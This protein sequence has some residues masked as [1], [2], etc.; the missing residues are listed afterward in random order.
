MHLSNSIQW[1][2]GRKPIIIL[3]WL[4]SLVGGAGAQDSRPAPLPPGYTSIFGEILSLESASDPKCHATASRLE[5][6]VYGTP[7]SDTARFRKNELASALAL[8]IWK[9]GAANNPDVE[10]LQS[11][12]IQDALKMFPAIEAGPDGSWLVRTP[13]GD[14]LSITERD[15]RQYS[16]IAYSLRAILAAQ[17]QVTIR[18]I[19]F[20]PL[21][22]S[23]VEAMKEAVDVFQL[24][25]L[26]SADQ[27]ARKVNA[28]EITALNM[29]RSWAVV[30]L[31]LNDPINKE[32]GEFPSSDFFTLQ[33]II[34]QKVA[35][36]AT[37]NEVSNQIFLRNL[38]VYFAKRRWP[39]DP[40]SGATL[41]N[42]IAQIIVNFAVELYHGAD[43]SARDRHDHLIREQDVS[44]FA[45]KF[46]AHRINEYED[47]IF[48]PN[49]ERDQQ[50]FIESY[51][52]DSFRDS[53]L[54]W[55][56][57]QFALEDASF[58]GQ[59]GA[60]PFAA[61][62]LAE[63]IAQFGVLVL[64]I[65]GQHA[66][67]NGDERLTTAHFDSGLRDLQQ[68]IVAHGK[69][70]PQKSGDD[71]IVSS[72]TTSVQSDAGGPLFKDVA[73]TMGID[74][75]HRSSDWLSRQLR[76]Y[77]K[78]GE[79]TG[80]ITIPPAFG[81]SGIAAEDVNHDN[82]PDLLVLSGLGN[83]LYLNQ[84]GKTFVDYTE[85]SGIRWQRPEDGQPGEPRQPIIADFD[86]DGHQDIFISYVDDHHRL[87]KG[88]GNGTF[89][90]V[91]ESCGLGGKGLVGGPATAFGFRSRWQ[92]RHLHHLLRGLHQWRAA[93]LGSAQ[94]QRAARQAF[95]KRGR[96]AVRRGEASWR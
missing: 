43:A 21:S 57:L 19:Q 67:E 42:Y 83:R 63:N 72:N 91:T 5:N 80:N 58:K 64:R 47:A 76:S 32:T 51:D 71:T 77:L 20:P 39:A 92:A 17:Q 60:D 90:D 84:E 59:L 89:T 44:Q 9:A 13:K 46:V 4:I 88:H 73:V 48:F 40:E 24:A 96:N 33:Q 28:Q 27:F 16:S 70:K 49:L 31:P 53:G 62:L 23:A 18:K 1:F 56:Y 79:E 2:N 75:Q 54:H 12:H 14:T 86:N 10:T 95:P 45:Q 93:H 81:G 30:G 25:A 85:K 8:H 82:W 87:Y 78:T 15:K 36:Y 66:I 3:L 52:M 38:Q 55:R 65:A 26:Q 94:S 69:A 68:R 61:E 74:Y 11:T 6:F 29:K 34:A 50:V 35:A 22:E 7:L 41:K 37:Y